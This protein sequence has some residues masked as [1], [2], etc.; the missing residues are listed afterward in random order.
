MR[1]EIIGRARL[2]L[3]DCREV[4]PAL[5]KV[6]AVITDPPYGVGLTYLGYVDTPE[7]LAE[8][9][10]TWLPAARAIAN[11]VVFTTGIKTIA[12]YPQ[13]DWILCWAI[14]GAGG[15]SPWGFSCWQPIMAY[16]TD[17]YLAAGLGSRPDLI[18]KNETAEKNGHPCPKPVGFMKALLGRA[19]LDGH[20]IVDPFLGAGSTGVAAVQMGRSFT[21]IERE[22]KYFDIACKRI[23]D[24]QRQ[25]DFFVGEAA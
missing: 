12:L 22:P 13:P 5:P 1:E 8:L 9:A 10:A 7:N 4:L 3:G 6:D 18:F 11:R 23:E 19:S 21:G 17:P 25:G 14:S 24:A 15:M 2:I 20:T 16:G